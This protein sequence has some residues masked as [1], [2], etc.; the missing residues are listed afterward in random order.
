MPL[1]R[2]QFLL[3]MPACSLAGLAPAADS[4]E[5]AVPSEVMSELGAARQQGSARLRFLG[6]HI[7]DIQLWSQGPL[8]ADTVF[9]VPLALVIDYARD[10]TGS[11]I[12]SRSID[13]MGRQGRADEQTVQRWLAAMTGLFPDVRAGDRITGV[14]RPNEATRFFHNGRVLGEVRDAL[15]TRRFF[16]IWLAPQTSE[17]T[18]RLQLLGRSS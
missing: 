6:L 17:P 13:E 2:R 15:F 8:A 11:K 1:N 18:M 7:Y 10:L 14:Q 9:D 4:A 3:H 16:G 12:A 5:P